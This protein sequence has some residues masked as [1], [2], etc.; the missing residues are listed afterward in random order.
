MAGLD[1]RFMDFI[2]DQAAAELRLFVTVFTHGVG[3]LGLNGKLAIREERLSNLCRME[4][5]DNRPTIS[6]N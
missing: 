2:H 4:L 1:L 6:S 5:R 3:S